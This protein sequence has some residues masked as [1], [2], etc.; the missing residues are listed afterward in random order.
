[1]D[2]KDGRTHSF[3]RVGDGGHNSRESQES[4]RSIILVYDVSQVT[5][6]FRL[7]LSNRTSFRHHRFAS[8]PRKLST[9]ERGRE[10]DRNNA[11][12][13][14]IHCQR[15]VPVQFDVSSSFHSCVGEISPVAAFP[16]GTAAPRHVDEYQ[17]DHLGSSP[18]SLVISCGHRRS[19]GNT[20]YCLAS[21]E[22]SKC[23]YHCTR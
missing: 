7:D 13:P 17:C 21:S 12:G 4:S 18:V 22:G 1:M 20:D 6:S 3:G 10:N 14:L 9:E 2:G 15:S 8:V 11:L 16:H 5:L 23:S 19:T